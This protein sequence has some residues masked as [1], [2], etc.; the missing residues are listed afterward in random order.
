MPPVNVEKLPHH[1][2]HTQNQSKYHFKLSIWF[3]IQCWMA[4]LLR[5]VWSSLSAMKDS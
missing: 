3:S 2:H 5:T 4:L 1:A